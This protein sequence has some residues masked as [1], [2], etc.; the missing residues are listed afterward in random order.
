MCYAVDLGIQNV[1]VSC[2]RYVNN[3][4]AKLM[5]KY[6]KI[7]TCVPKKHTEFMKVVP[8]NKYLHLR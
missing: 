3:S 1:K 6:A 5:L 8:Q 4:H 7:C 2:L